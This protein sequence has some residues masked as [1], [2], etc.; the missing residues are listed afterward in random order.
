[1]ETKEKAKAL[2]KFLP[3]HVMFKRTRN[4]DGNIHEIIVCSQ[5]LNMM[6]VD[7]GMVLYPRARIRIRIGQ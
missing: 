3:Q 5:I 7:I 2:E 6:D 1:M 4:R